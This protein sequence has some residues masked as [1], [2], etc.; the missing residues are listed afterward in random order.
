MVGE[1]E[2]GEQLVFFKNE[3]G[4][5]GF[6]RTRAEVEGAK[7]LKTANEKSELRLKS[8]APLA[9]VKG[10]EKGVI[11]GLH[12]ALRVEALS[13]N[14]RQRALANAY[15]TFHGD[16]AGQFEKVGH[17]LED[18]N[19]EWQDIPAEPEAQLR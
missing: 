15:G 6:L 1:I 8:G 2:A 19:F 3:I 18:S 16:V 17:E 9:I 4:D 7:L 5:Y 11:V 12:D 13:Q 14:A 10:A